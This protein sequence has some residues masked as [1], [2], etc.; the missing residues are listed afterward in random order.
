MKLVVFVL[1]VMLSMTG[2]VEAEYSI[3]KNLTLDYD[4]SVSGEGYFMTYKYARM[5]NEIGREVFESYSGIDSH[6]S[7]GVEVLDYSHGSGII[8]TESLFSAETASAKNGFDES[9]GYDYREALS[10]I[11]MRESADLR[12]SPE[13]IAI[14][15]G[16][17]AANPT[18]YSSLVKE[19]TWTKNRGSATSMRHEVEYAHGLD[20]DLDLLVKNFISEEDPSVSLLNVSEDVTNGRT[21]FGLLHGPV[22]AAEMGEDDL[23]GPGS[24]LLRSAIKFPEIEIDEDYIGTFHFEKRMN[25]TASIEEVVEDDDWLPCCSGGYAD[26]ADHDKAGH[27]AD[28]VFDCT[29]PNVSAHAE[30]PR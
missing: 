30:F 24:S 28:G 8:N 6:I 7:N 3:M 14:G 12:F 18:T 11:T 10:C 15:T 19:N 29:C 4:Q 20:K 25:L 9:Y 1:I 21:H 13:T 17:Y 5:P 16:F 27:S 22:A 26:M 23:I 2:L